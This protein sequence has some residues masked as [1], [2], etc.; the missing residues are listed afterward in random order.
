MQTL[1]VL[2]QACTAVHIAAIVN[3]AVSEMHMRCLAKRLFYACAVSSKALQ[4]L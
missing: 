2:L 4:V 1:A 3:I